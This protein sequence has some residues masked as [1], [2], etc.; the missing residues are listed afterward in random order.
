MVLI[1]LMMLAG[2]AIVFG[3]AVGVGKILGGIR[4]RIDAETE[5]LKNN[6]EQRKDK[7]NDSK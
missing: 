6:Y 7:T 4:R 1:V 3:V 5:N 2:G